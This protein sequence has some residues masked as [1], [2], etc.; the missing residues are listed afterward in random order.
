MYCARTFS[1]TKAKDEAGRGRGGGESAFGI[2]WRDDAAVVDGVV[3][4]V[5][6]T[7]KGTLILLGVCTFTGCLPVGRD[8]E[9]MLL[10]GEWLLHD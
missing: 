8:C 10:L 4:A 3:S 7:C 2:L 6:M 5:C 1:N 9:R